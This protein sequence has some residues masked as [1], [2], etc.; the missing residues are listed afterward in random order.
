MMVLQSSSTRVFIHE[1]TMAVSKSVSGWSLVVWHEGNIVL[2]VPLRALMVL[3]VVKYDEAFGQ[4][5]CGVL[6]QPSYSHYV[7]TF[8][9]VW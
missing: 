6:M 5:A 4:N 9:V 3:R 7:I 1:R 2:V 8:R